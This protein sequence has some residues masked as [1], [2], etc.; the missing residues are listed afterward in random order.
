MI[1]I[2]LFTSSVMGELTTFC[3]ILWKALDFSDCKKIIVFPGRIL[4]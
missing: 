2:L 1:S 4:L 3:G